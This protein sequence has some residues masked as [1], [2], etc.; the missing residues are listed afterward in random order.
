[1]TNADYVA[2]AI[3]PALVMALVGSLVFFLIEV[4]YVGNYTGRLNYVF[5]LFVFATVLIARIAIEMGSERA[6]M[7][8]LPMGLLMFIALGKFVEHTGPLGWLVNLCLLA[9]VWWSSHKLTWDCTVIDDDEDSSG[10]GLLGRVGLDPPENAAEPAPPT[11][12]TATRS[13][14]AHGANANELFNDPAEG[15]APKLSWWQRLA[16]AGT[17]PHTPGL[18]VLYFS[19]AALP[20][21][22]IGQHWIPAS[23]VGRRQYA[24]GLLAVYV[25]A[26]LSLL[27]TTSFLGLRRYLRQ[28]NVEMPA[29][30]AA[31]WVA[32]GAAL[33]VVVMLAAALLPR[34]A[35]EYAAAQPPWRLGSRNDQSSSAASVGSEGTV[36]A[37]SDEQV[38]SDNQP[39]AEATGEASP[40]AQTG[41][42]T[43]G[44]EPGNGQ[45]AGQGQQD[46]QDSSSSGSQNSSDSNANG[47][48]PQEA[49]QSP[50]AEDADRAGEGES[51]SDQTQGERDASP[52]QTAD[53]SQSSSDA[54]S[55]TSSQSNQPNESPTTPQPEQGSAPSEQSSPSM[56][57]P[58]FSAIA[59][60]LSNSL[61]D[62]VKMIAYILLGVAIAYFAWRNWPAIV[63]AFLE[64]MQMIRDLIARLFGAKPAAAGGNDAE[65]SAPTAP[66][67]RSFSEYTDPFLSGRDRQTS[68]NEL[69]RYTFEAF[70]AW[71]C[72]RGQARSP[73]QTPQEFVRLAAP[74]A[75]PLHDEARR[76]LQLYSA[77]AYASANIPREAAAGLRQ[78]WHLMQSAR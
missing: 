53:E 7:F 14:A 20:L 47:E 17:G 76:L 25:A 33:I 72:D 69:V 13:L 63:R 75:S 30:M 21:F 52:E 22:G 57:P 36:D 60:M 23:D 5:A 54:S 44:S 67:R 29:P 66:P 32:M 56:Q 12:P 34:P 48:P 15:E 77:A 11:V 6:A 39:D 31:T 78:L 28:R 50:S 2:I 73:E 37:T 64:I 42:S 41:E 8:S 74:P 16:S 59:G 24:F 49:D 70:E 65:S 3:S 10:E 27:V 4:L 68:P 9:A 19:L 38:T 71:S 18:W 51:P 62:I 58:N 1:M 26:G 55:Q 61:A 45:P 40:D 35:A 43:A 46:T